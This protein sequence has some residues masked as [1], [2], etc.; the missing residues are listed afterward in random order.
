MTGVGMTRVLIE[1]PPNYNELV[2]LFPIAG[3]G[4]IFSWRPFIYNP[5]NVRISPQL[6]AHEAVHQFRQY[7]DVEG[8]WRRYVDDT[9]FRLREEALGHRA[10][11]R[12]VVEMG[13]NRHQRRSEAKKIAKRLASPVYGSLVSQR[14]AME[15]IT[16]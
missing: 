7:G 16:L 1:R 14:Y 13:M 15:L 10:E 4:V 12:K 5:M 11:L 6:F 8:W 2:K 9:E 3:K